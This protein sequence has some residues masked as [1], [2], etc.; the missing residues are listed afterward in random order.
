MADVQVEKGYTPVANELAEQFARC[1]LSGLEW[2][3]VWVILR[4]TYGWSRKADRISVAQVS[5]A[6]RVPLRS[7]KRALVAL[8]ER[9]ILVAEGDDKHIKLWSINKNYEEW[10]F[11]KPG[12]KGDEIDPYIGDETDPFAS[13]EGTKLTPNEGTKQTPNEGTKSSPTKTSKSSKSKVVVD[14]ACDVA[15]TEEER[16]CLTA[17]MAIEVNGKR[18]PFDLKRDIEHLRSLMAEYPTVDLYQTI[19]DYR[20]WLFDHPPKAG[21]SP[22]LAI[23]NWAKSDFERGKNLRKGVQRGVRVNAGSRSGNSGNHD[24]PG[25]RERIGAFASAVQR[26][27]EARRAARGLS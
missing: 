6:T 17:L 23:R 10:A 12:R 22:R 21:W 13:R 26:Q 2:R 8:R 27:A 11:D 3:V 15:I 16:D 4:Q 5:E 9:R 1:D 7:A 19:G 18:Y 25:G 20:T 14:G 24:V